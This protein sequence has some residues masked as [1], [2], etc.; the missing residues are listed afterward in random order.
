MKKL[1]LLF[2]YAKKFNKLV[3]F[4]NEQRDLYYIRTEMDAQN[5]I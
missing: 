4:F 1:N 5:H 3:F 2:E